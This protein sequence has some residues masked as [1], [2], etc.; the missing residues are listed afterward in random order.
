M[1][2]FM[3]HVEKQEWTQKKPTVDGWYWVYWEGG[4]QLPTL[5]EVGGS[6]SCAYLIGQ[7]P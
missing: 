5:A 3:Q 6:A 7:D 2:E 4:W 1:S